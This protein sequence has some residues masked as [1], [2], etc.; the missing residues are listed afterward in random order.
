MVYSVRGD[1]LVYSWF[2]N[3]RKFLQKIG[4]VSMTVYD[5]DVEILPLV[6]LL[7]IVLGEER[8][9]KQYVD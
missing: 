3:R 2:Y 5:G 8:Q 1:G 6:I 4:K 9:R 7:A